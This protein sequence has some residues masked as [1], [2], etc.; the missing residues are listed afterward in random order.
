MKRRVLIAVLISIA[1]GLFINGCVIEDEEPDIYPP[2]PPTGVFS[3]TGDSYVDIYW[4]DNYEPD[5]A[6]YNVYWSYY[7]NGP[8]YV[9]D[10]TYNTYY[11]DWD[12]TN[13]ETYFYAVTAFDYSGNESE[14]SFDT[15]FD[16]PRP[17]G[18]G[19]MLIGYG[20]TVPD[21][22]GY[23]FS[24]Y[25]VTPGDGPY[26]DFYFYYD[27]GTG[28]YYLVA[29]GLTRVQDVGYCEY[30]EEVGW[31]PSSG[32]STSGVVEIILDHCYVFLTA[33]NNYAKIKVTNF[34]NAGGFNYLYF[35][36]AY[37]TDPDN[38]ELRR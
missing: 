4:D 8:Y 19:V 9:M 23:D 24:D 21:A 32:W 34:Y 18:E 6:G 14:L 22:S 20:E 33:T 38:P 27:A 2:N 30:F 7:E 26:A 29:N 15:V 28:G 17:E 36:W 10:T 1:L 31:A 12:V 13:G 25:S 16:T 35:D 11:T 5:L 3:V 37:Q